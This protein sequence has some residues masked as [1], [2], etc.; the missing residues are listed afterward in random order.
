MA[1]AQICRM[2]NLS[3][4]GGSAE[5][6]GA[7]NEMGCGVAGVVESVSHAINTGCVCGDNAR[8][9]PAISVSRS[10]IIEAQ[11]AASVQG[12][13][14]MLCCSGQPLQGAVSA[15]CTLAITQG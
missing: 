11:A 2:Q 4:G 6:L 9:N 7:F 15:A 13:S 12:T 3:K 8:A 14:L 10:S 5:L 1:S